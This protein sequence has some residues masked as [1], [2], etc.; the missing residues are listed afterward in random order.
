ML[1]LSLRMIAWWRVR[2]KRDDETAVAVARTAKPQFQIL[3]NKHLLKLTMTS[4]STSGGHKCIP[5][6]GLLLRRLLI[7]LSPLFIVQYSMPTKILKQILCAN[8]ENKTG[9]PH[10][11]LT[12]H[13]IGTHQ[14]GCACCRAHPVDG[15]PSYSYKQSNSNTVPWYLI[16]ELYVIL[17]PQW[18]KHTPVKGVL[19][20]LCPILRK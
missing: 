8:A 14:Q 6:N 3:T 7:T 20:I 12:T 17:L 2:V 4:V 1:P 11:S 9:I 15:R 10:L 18:W 16:L 19:H 5:E 13:I